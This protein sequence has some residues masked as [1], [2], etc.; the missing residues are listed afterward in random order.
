MESRPPA[1]LFLPIEPFAAGWLNVGRGHRVY[2]E[3]CGN[4]AGV[5]VL[6]VHGGPGSGSSPRLRQCLDPARHRL[7]LADQRGCGRS[8][9][10][11]ETAGNDTR[12]LIADIER[13]RH[14][15]GLRRWLVVGGSWGAT[16]AAAYAAEHRRAVAG[17]VLRAI[18]LTGRRDLDWFFGGAG[19]LFPQAWAAFAAAVPGRGRLLPRLAAVLDGDDAAAA[20]RA[21]LAWQD[22]ERVLTGQPAAAAP[23]DEDSVRLHARYCIQATYLLR[24]CDLGEARVL[25]AIVRLRGLPVTLIHGRRDLVCR[26]GNAWRAHRAL[27]GSQL[28]WVDDGGHDPLT[29]GML[30]ALQDSVAE[31]AATW[32]RQ[33]SGR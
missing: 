21:A 22:W 18:F 25:R 14:H 7:I 6:L 29:P 3:Q 19:R 15:L 8:L 33:G 26:P 13:L 17:L 20:R 2:H 10:L 32:G 24:H 11:G 16:L 9:P 31:L 30:G 5:P 27:P 4:P 23:N 28:L 12:G 1:T